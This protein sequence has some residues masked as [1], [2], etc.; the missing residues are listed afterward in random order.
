MEGVLIISTTTKTCTVE[1]GHNDSV[2]SFFRKR[3]M[4]RTDRGPAEAS[5]PAETAMC[6][7]DIESLYL[8]A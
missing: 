7:D 5:V 2:A 8:N 3:K 4:R 6:G 1:A